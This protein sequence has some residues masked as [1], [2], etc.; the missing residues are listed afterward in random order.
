MG[1]ENNSI[2]QIVKQSVASETPL[3]AADI[4]RLRKKNTKAIGLYKLVFWVAIALF[5]VFL[6]VPLQIP[7]ALQIALIIVSL[8]CAFIVPIYG[9]RKH[10]KILGFLGDTAS[11]PKKSRA[12]D[13]G[14]TYISGVRQEGRSFVKAEV[15]VLEASREPTS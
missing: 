10:Q 12:S 6:F 1:K 9:I 5:N 14:R 8:G 3:S 15:D 13:E 11:G 7:D 2:H 4:R